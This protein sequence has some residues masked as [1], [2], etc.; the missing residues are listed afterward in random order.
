MKSPVL[1][2]CMRPSVTATDCISA[3]RAARHD[4]SHPRA[5]TIGQSVSHPWLGHSVNGALRTAALYQLPP[6]RPASLNNRADP[7]EAETFIAVEASKSN[8][9]P[10]ATPT[11]LAKDR[12]PSRPRT[13]ALLSSVNELAPSWAAVT[14][15]KRGAAFGR[16]QR[17]RG[18]APVV[19]EDISLLM[20]A[21]SCRCSLI[22]PRASFATLTASRSR[23]ERR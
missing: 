23:P 14:A 2:G 11:S 5:A 15:I 21:S 17:L 1:I 20:S 13:T 19:A 7:I 6:C 10:I 9:V 22:M 12:I 3:A 4:S 16:P 8:L 18:A